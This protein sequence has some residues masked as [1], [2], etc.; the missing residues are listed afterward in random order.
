[1]AFNM[2]AQGS[3]ITNTS[4]FFSNPDNINVTAYGVLSPS[5]NHLYITIINKTFQYVGAHAAS[6]TIPAPGNFSTPTSARYLLL[7][8]EPAGQEGNA[9][10][11][12][13]AYLGGA[14]IPNNGQWSG[15]WEPLTLG[16]QNQVT[17]IV[18]PATAVIIDLQN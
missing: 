5:K 14:T 13:T 12:Q 8:C 16:S 17:M 4:S 9:S 1:M 3:P 2:G 7:S 11:L 15:A 6:V 18:Q 10:A